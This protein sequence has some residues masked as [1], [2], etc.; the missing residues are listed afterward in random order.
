MAVRHDNTIH[1]V[2]YILQIEPVPPS[3]IPN[4]VNPL[5]SP[6]KIDSSLEFKVAQ[7]LDFKLD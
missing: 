4:H 3:N 7:I 5:L 1:P 6:I 2:F